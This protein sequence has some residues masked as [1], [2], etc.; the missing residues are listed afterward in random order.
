MNYTISS[1]NLPGGKAV[2]FYCNLVTSCS[3]VRKFSSPI[4]VILM[5]EKHRKN[6]NQGYLEFGF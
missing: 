6:E 3:E 4:I 5:S 2:T 1:K